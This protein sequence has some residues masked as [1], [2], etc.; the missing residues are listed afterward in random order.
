MKYVG[1]M[2]VA[3][4]GSLI[5]APSQQWQNTNQSNSNQ[6]NNSS[7][8]QGSQQ[9]HHHSQSNRHGQ[10]YQSSGSSQQNQYYRDSGTQNQYYK[11]SGTQQHHSTQNRNYHNNPSSQNFSTTRGQNT[12]IA[13]DAIA[14]NGQNVFLY[15]KEGCYHCHRVL[16]FLQKEN[17]DLSTKELNEN[18]SYR[19]HIRQLTGRV[20]VPALIVNGEVIMGADRIIEWLGENS[21]EV[22]ENI[23]HSQQRRM[24]NR[25]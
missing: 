12:F 3:V 21:V 10:H 9:T 13:E 17:I 18:P 2:C 25:Y 1:I 19:D 16:D 6:W 22:R 11:D 24:H 7:H 4:A 15:Y 14:T 5:G 23:P 20:R 8:K